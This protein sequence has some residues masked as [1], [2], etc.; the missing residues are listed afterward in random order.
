MANSNNNNTTVQWS[1]ANSKSLNSASRVNSDAI[2]IHADAMSAAV[3]VTVDNS[4]TPTSGDVVDLWC[5]FSLDGGTTWD[6]D[7]AATPLR[8]VDTYASNAT[9]EDPCVV[10]IPLPVSGKRSWRLSAAAPQGASRAITI[11]AVYNEH[12]AA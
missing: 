5:E 4:G 10:T 12:R 7:K 6:T 3:Q 8:R 11:S 9:G 1:G 2:A